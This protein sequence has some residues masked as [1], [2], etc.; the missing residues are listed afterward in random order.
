MSLNTNIQN[1][2]FDVVTMEQIGMLLMFIFIEIL[3]GAVIVW[4]NI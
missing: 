3:V 4:K 2:L 1:V